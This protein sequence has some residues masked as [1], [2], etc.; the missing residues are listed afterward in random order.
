MTTYLRR[1]ALAGVAA[2]AAMALFLLLVGERSISAA[3]AL[4][5]A[6]QGDGGAEPVFTRPQQLV[7]GV[8]G[9]VIAGLAMGAIFG[10]VFAALR[11]R[12]RGGDWQRSLT[13]AAIAFGS[14]FL[15]PFLKYPANPP[16]VGDPDTIGRRT[17]LYLVV[18]AWSI[19]SAWGAWRLHRWLV[20]RQLP[21]H[22]R[23]PAVAAVLV[24]LVVAGFV[25]LP[26]NPDPVAA[27]ATLIWRFRL[28]S[29]G[30]AALFWSVLGV[31]FG[32]LAIRE[33]AGRITAGAT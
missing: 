29:L 3:I 13:L 9:I 11:H 14:V 20:A 24:A 27:P 19:V 33:G 31:S 16:A 6:G 1:G 4:E 10:I 7:G 26:G 25:A 5:A 30:G 12:L 28:A 15:V 2:S 22:Q 32:W 18:L 21:A 8:A 17:A 23:G